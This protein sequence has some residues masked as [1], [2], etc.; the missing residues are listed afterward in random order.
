MGLIIVGIGLDHLC[1]VLN[2]ETNYLFLIAGTANTI[3]VYGDDV[4]KSLVFLVE[5][6]K[7]LFDKVLNDQ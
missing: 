3:T 5:D 6:F 2:L 7:T 4:W 1:Y